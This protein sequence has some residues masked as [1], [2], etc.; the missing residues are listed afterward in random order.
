MVWLLGRLVLGVDTGSRLCSESPSCK[1]LIYLSYFFDTVVCVLMNFFACCSAESTEVL[2]PSTTDGRRHMK[3]PTAPHTE[4]AQA[5]ADPV[6]PTVEQPTVAEPFT[7]TME[8]PSTTGLTSPGVGLHDE[9]DPDVEEA[10]DATMMLSGL[11]RA[12]TEPTGYA[13]SSATQ[14]P[15]T[16]AEQA[17]S[18]ATSTTGVVLGRSV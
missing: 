18:A 2:Q 4:Q 1:C 16:V 13:S 6:T 15:P 17:S 3:E 9:G 7:S 14:G 5:R 10:W 12:G 11:A 8:E